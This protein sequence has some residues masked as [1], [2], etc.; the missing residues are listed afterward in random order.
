MNDPF[1]PLQIQPEAQAPRGWKHP[2]WLT[3]IAVVALLCTLAV[4]YILYY[5]FAALLGGAAA[6][7]NAILNFIRLL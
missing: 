1:E 5:A 4:C 3:L 6:F 2:A 7:V